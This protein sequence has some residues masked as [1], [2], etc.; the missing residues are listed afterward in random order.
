MNESFR[1]SRIRAPRSSLTAMVLLAAVFI[2]FG[3]LMSALAPEQAAAAPRYFDSSA[4]TFAN[5][6]LGG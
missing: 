3:L 6:M 2:A 5:W 4:L 1:L